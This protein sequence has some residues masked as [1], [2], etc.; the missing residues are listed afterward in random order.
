MINEHTS[1]SSQHE[2]MKRGEGGWKVAGA[3]TAGG[4]DAAVPLWVWLYKWCMRKPKQ[5]NESELHVCHKWAEVERGRGN[6]LSVLGGVC[7]CV[8]E[9]A[10]CS[11]SFACVCSLCLH[12]ANMQRATGQGQEQKRGHGGRGTR[13]VL[14]PHQQAKFSFC[15]C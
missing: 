15:C 10:L 12:L 5:Q 3:G 14:P 9:L 1:N 13:F 11:A 8:R 2:P 7:V 4:A 6:K